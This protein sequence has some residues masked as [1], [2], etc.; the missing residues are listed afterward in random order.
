MRYNMLQLLKNLRFHSHGKEINDGDILQWANTKV[1]S[2]GSKSL[3]N[4]FKVSFTEVQD[5]IYY[6]IVMR[7]IFVLFLIYEYEDTISA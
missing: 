5:D 1:K 4:S 3:M 2:S 7:S 6:L